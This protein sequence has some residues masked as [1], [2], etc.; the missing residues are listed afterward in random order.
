[1]KKKKK[2]KKK[3][4]RRRRR[5]RRKKSIRS[6][7]LKKLNR[8]INMSRQHQLTTVTYNNFFFFL[9]KNVRYS[10]F[11]ILINHI[12]SIHIKHQVCK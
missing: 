5:R 4:G 2:K 3:R 12:Y 10:K 11:H 7:P 1:M 6:L 9:K 8:I